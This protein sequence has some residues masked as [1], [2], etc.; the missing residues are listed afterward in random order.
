MTKIPRRK[1]LYGK[2][3]TPTSEKGCII[4]PDDSTESFYKVTPLGR[5]VAKNTD[6]GKRVQIFPKY[7]QQSFRSNC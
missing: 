6:T 2:I 7:E 1:G 3:E 4:A 5:P